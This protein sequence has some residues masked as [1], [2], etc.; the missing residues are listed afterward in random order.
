NTLTYNLVNPPAGAQISANGVIAWT[1]SEAQ[2][3]S[4]NLITTVVSDNGI[5]PLSATNTFTV[6]V[7]EVNS[8][9]LLTVPPDQTINELA[10]LSVSAS[11]TDSDIPANSLLFSLLS[12]PV[13]MT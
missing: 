3:A 8:A 6:I 2:G 10:T 13:G 1:P 9:P 4:T 12:P 11:A 5:P 7:T